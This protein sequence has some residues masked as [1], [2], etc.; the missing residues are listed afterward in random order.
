MTWI[1]IRTGIPNRYG[2]LKLLKAD[3]IWIWINNT[4]LRTMT[5]TIMLFRFYNQHKQLLVQQQ[6]QQQQAGKQPPPATSSSKRVGAKRGKDSH[7]SQ[8]RIHSYS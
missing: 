4:A 5:M 3:P 7:L 8:V 2:F 1:K 6:Q